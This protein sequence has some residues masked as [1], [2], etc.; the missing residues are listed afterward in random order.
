MDFG[1][2]NFMRCHL[3]RKGYPGNPKPG[4]S[5]G[6][7]LAAFERVGMYFGVSANWQTTGYVPR[8]GKYEKPDNKAIHTEQHL[9]DCL[10]WTEKF[11]EAEYLPGLYGG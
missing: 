1:G 8:T 11:L 4:N 10:D 3:T 2:F 6:V 7:L 5:D 9:Q